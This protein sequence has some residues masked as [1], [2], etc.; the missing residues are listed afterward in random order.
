MITPVSETR[1]KLSMSV[2]KRSHREFRGTRGAGKV[3][4]KIKG[5]KP[6]S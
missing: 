5:K 1:E 4:R 2:L 6:P 3:I